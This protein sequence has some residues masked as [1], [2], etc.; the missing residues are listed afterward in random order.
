MQYP[1]PS[2]AEIEAAAQI[3]FEEARFYRW[4]PIATDSYAIFAES[5]PI[6]VSELRGI[7]ERMLLAAARAQREARLR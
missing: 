2:P 3:L 1:A 4:F 6:G 5:N 7:A